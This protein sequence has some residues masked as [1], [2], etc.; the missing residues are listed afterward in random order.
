MNRSYAKLKKCVFEQ[1]SLPFLGSIISETGLRMDPE[2]E[3]TVL[4]WPRPDSLKSIQRF[5]EFANY[6]R[7]F[8]PHFASHTTSISAL[9]RKGANSRVWN[10]EAES[11]F[12]S[13]KQASASA[14]VLH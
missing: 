9:T 11:A 12:V 3:S 14:P 6:Y 7:Q 2:K 13:L 10:L 4:N 5:L 1:T 8:I